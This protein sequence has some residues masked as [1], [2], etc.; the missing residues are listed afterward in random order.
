MTSTPHAASPQLRPPAGER[1]PAFKRHIPERLFY[2][3]PA[4]MWLAL[5]IRYRSLTLPS[6]ANP[7][8][9]A[10]G[11]W[12]ES[13]SQGLDLFGPLGRAQLARFACLQCD[14]DAP[15]DCALAAMAEAGLD[16]P[17]VAKPDRGY[18]GW[19]VRLIQR[20]E[21]LA[22]YLAVQPPGA[23]VLLQELVDLPGEAG[24]FYLR[25]PDQAR[26]RIVS[27]AFVYPPHV[28]GDGRRSVA[29]LV[30]ADKVLRPNSAI[31]RGRHPESWE[32]VP[33]PGAFHV[34][35]NAR[36]ARLGAVYRD[37]LPLVTPQLEALIDE[38]SREIP[39]FHFGRFDIRFRSPEDLGAARDFR[40]LELNGAG[41]EMLHFWAGD[42]TLR[43]AYRA[44][45]RQYRWL[46]AIGATMRARGARPVGLRG[47]IRLQRQQEALRRIYPPSS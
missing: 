19:G 13:K 27:M 10:G 38:I 9:E 25:H 1:Y 31:Y 15:L 11:L 47:M 42:G 32:T 43:Q 35:T 3:L 17:V 26:G 7:A 4:L 29:Q 24:I 14:A 2:L 30:Q 21:D 37:A 8:M 44:L 20:A 16:F 6:A 41:A 36:S 45:W 46:F 28:I 33:G 18:Q 22:A 40:I 5:A 23:A 12:G 39:D 34:L